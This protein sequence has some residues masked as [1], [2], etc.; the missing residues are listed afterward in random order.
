MQNQDNENHPQP[1]DTMV[2]S[3]QD[4]EL[5]LRVASKQRNSRAAAKKAAARK[6]N[7]GATRKEQATT[8]KKADVTTPRAATDE[9]LGL[10]PEGKDNN[11]VV[12][13]GRKA[14]E[15]ERIHGTCDEAHRHANS[16]EMHIFK[17]KQH[18][19]S[20]KSTHRPL[21]AD[22]ELN[23]S[24]MGLQK[25]DIATAANE[26]RGASNEGVTVCSPPLA[27]DKSAGLSPRMKWFVLVGFLALAVVVVTVPAVVPTDRQ[28][29]VAEVHAFNQTFERTTTHI[30][31][32]NANHTGGLPSE[33]VLLTALTSLNLN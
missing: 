3:E 5:G 15:E 13:A 12:G 4:K 18:H 20:Q 31:L 2:A 21:P 22:V 17:I 30:D 26:T 1:K 8:K 33:L 16:G 32:H 7:A 19:R 23:E 27:N 24:I 28:K 9:E 14:A 11:R 10:G 6:S 25:S 29:P